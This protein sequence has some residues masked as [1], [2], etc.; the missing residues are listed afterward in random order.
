MPFRPRIFS[1]SALSESASLAGKS[2]P[3]FQ[4]PYAATKAA[5]VGFTVSLR[6]T[7]RG[8]GVSASVI[9]PSFVEA[10]IYARLKAKSG[11]SAPA[12]LTGCTAELVAE[13]VLRAIRDDVPEIIINRY[14]IRPVLA[15]SAL[16]PRLGDW[17]VTRLGVHDFFR[18]VLEAEKRKRV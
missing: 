1:I 8:S 12:L 17:I 2:G 6:A 9:V 14:P 15:L 18:R 11:C 7:Y 3:A 10:G 13:A 4:E 5:L 16:S